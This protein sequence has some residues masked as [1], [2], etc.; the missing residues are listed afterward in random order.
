MIQVSKEW[1]KTNVANIVDSMG[2]R[3]K[4]H[5]LTSVRVPR[6]GFETNLSP[7]QMTEAER[8]KIDFKINIP[9]N[10]GWC[11]AQTYSANNR[12][13]NMPHRRLGYF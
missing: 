11:N 13:R 12:P 8:D 9:G 4:N 3:R 7:E 10:I 6:G 5:I 2:D 1:I